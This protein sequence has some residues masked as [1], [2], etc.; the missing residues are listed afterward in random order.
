MQPASASRRPGWRRPGPS[1]QP[2]RRQSTGRAAASRRRNRG[3]AG[4]RDTP[5]GPGT[6]AGG[7]MPAASRCAVSSASRR[8]DSSLASQN[9]SLTAK[10][11]APRSRRQICPTAPRDPGMIAAS[12]TSG[13]PKAAQIQPTVVVPARITRSPNQ[14][15]P[16]HRQRIS[17][18]EGRVA[19][20]AD[21]VNTTA[22]RSA[23]PPGRFLP[24]SAVGLGRRQDLI[25]TGR[26]DVNGYT[27][28]PELND[29]PDLHVGGSSRL[30]AHRDAAGQARPRPATP[31]RATS[32]A[33]DT[34]RRARSPGRQHHVRSRQVNG[35]AVARRRRAAHGLRSDL[36]RVPSAPNRASKGHS[37]S[38]GPR[39]PLGSAGRSPSSCQLPGQKRSRRHRSSHC[40]RRARE[41][42][43][44]RHRA[45]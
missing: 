19:E 7:P 40:A 31:R 23:I 32:L 9:S 4:R 6:L 17:A 29:R 37:G 24:G 25:G 12:G 26:R 1:G 30:G 21:A 10:R 5:P 15:T 36:H 35:E 39:G 16:G 34:V 11:F 45:R 42:P 18:A 28:I 27:K 3:A 13:S 2:A 14:P 44:R 41:G 33:I 38:F 20:P 22:A 43:D 8:A